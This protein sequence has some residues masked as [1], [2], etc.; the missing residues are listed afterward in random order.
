MEP[1]EVWVDLCGESVFTGVLYSHRRRDV[2][3]ATF[4]YDDSYLA[5]PDSYPL[6]PMLPLNSGPFHTPTTHSLFNA[7][8]DTSPDRWGRELVKRAERFRAQD[9]NER[10]RTLTES[11]FLLGVRD[12]LR[13]GALRFRIQGQDP[14]SAEPSAGVPEVTDLPDLLDLA[15]RVG[16]DDVLQEELRRLIHGGSSLGG[17]RPKA[18]M[19][20]PDGRI[21]IAKFPSEA[22]D[23]W[24]VMGWEKVALDLAAHAGISVPP[25]QLIRVDERDVLVVERFDRTADGKRIGFWSGVTLLETLDGVP[26]SYVEMA[27]RIEEESSDP[28]EDLQQL[29]RRIVLGILISNTDNHLRNHAFLR[30]GRSGWRLS[31]AFDLNPNPE[32]ALRQLA[33]PIDDGAFGADFDLLLEV[34]LAYFRLVRDEALEVL[35]EVREAVGHWTE[36]AESHGLSGV[37]IDQM[38]PAFSNE[39]SRRAADLTKG[40][41]TP[42]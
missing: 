34:A 18:H 10:P 41:R 3:S 30:T 23:R 29:W 37:E 15:D 26:R 24:N 11:D 7:F 38:T 20:T 4:R 39:V 25:S 40:T 14:F 22:N 21:A 6:D 9:Q 1:V 8:A 19:R 12:D 31:P 42:Y 35:R 32:P 28:T 16:T 17:A 36:V 13:Q 33:T 27:E 5:R 2:E